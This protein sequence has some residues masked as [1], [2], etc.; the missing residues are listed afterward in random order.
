M[1]MPSDS[2]KRV[3]RRADLLSIG[4]Y[5][6]VYL[7]RNPGYTGFHAKFRRERMV[8]EDETKELVLVEWL[9][10]HRRVEWNRDIPENEPLTCKSVGW[11]LRRGDRA[12]T[13]APHVSV[14]DDPQHCGEMTIP[15]CAVVQVKELEG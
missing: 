2:L 10:S 9:D 11:V 4:D 5:I 1:P 8:I 12:I 3:E 13:V 7:R 15:T 6:P 14:E